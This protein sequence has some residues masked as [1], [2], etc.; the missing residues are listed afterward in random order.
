[1]ADAIDCTYKRQ[2]LQR[3]AT[4]FQVFAYEDMAA[5]YPAQAVLIGCCE[6]CGQLIKVRADNMRSSAI[7]GKVRVF[8][9][10]HASVAPNVAIVHIPAALPQASCYKARQ[11]AADEVIVVDD[12]YVPASI[13]FQNAGEHATPFVQANTVTE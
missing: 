4:L 7:F 3:I 5:E 12:H 9:N 2:R 11:P 13:G 10:Q 8:I 1:M 6:A